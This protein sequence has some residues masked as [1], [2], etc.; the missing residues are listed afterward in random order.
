MKR[1]DLRVISKNKSFIYLFIFVL[2]CGNNLPLQSLINTNSEKNKI[3]FLDKNYLKN[4][5][6]QDYQIGSGDTLVIKISRLHP[7]LDS[8]VTVDGEGTISLPR[9]KRIFIKDL[10]VRELTNLL[11]ESY[12]EYIINPSVDISILT[13]RPIKIYLKG[14]LERPGIKVL[15]G[16]MT[17]I[18][19]VNDNQN[20]QNQIT[21]YFPTIFD[22]IRAA[23]GIT[24]YSD[25]SNIRIIRKNTISE[26]GGLLSTIINFE[27]FLK[28]G[29]PI[30]NIRVYDSDIIEVGYSDKQ[31][32][33][34]LSKAI[35]S[36]LNPRFV[37]VF[38]FGRVNNPGEI[39]IS[40][41][42]VLSDAVDMAGGAKF[43]RGSLKF[44]RLNN[45]GSIDKRS[46]KYKANRKRNS[47]MNPML[48][49]GDLI[50]I[51][52]STFSVANSV[53]N[54]FTSPLTGL[55]STYGIIQ[56]IKN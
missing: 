21:N 39:K 44:I 53:I 19:G 35:S 28:D 3:S 6:E 54:E 43:V 50:I 23:E 9:L 42:S 29:D 51:G 55:F 33:T 14:E 4:V 10:T 8:K 36:G 30:S 24:E 49:N 16:S 22:A 13:Y 26:G 32:D 47:Y 27:S 20:N 40:R 56:A 37:N 45:D 5:P 7:E 34:N 17:L 12:Q 52:E 2:F 1:L 38:V 15:K 41:A 18:G 48:K 46:F 25:L 31:N 11:N